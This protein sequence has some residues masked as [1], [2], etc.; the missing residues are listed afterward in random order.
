MKNKKLVTIVMA[1]LALT[2]LTIGTLA[3]FTDRFQSEVDVTAGTL[4]LTLSQNWESDNAA[5]AAKF[6]PGTGLVLN[7]TL[8]N[9]GNLAANV[10]EKIVIST[11]KDLT[12]AAP[13]FALYSASDVDVAADGDVT[14]HDGATPIA[15]VAGT[16]TEEGTGNTWHKLTY[17]F[18]PFVLNGNVEQPD[19]ASDTKGGAY[20]VVFSTKATNDFQAATLK[21]EYLA[22]GLQYG[23]TGADTWAD[24]KVI[25]AEITFGGEK[26]NVV[27]ELPAVTP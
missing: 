11:D 21:V 10:K 7:Y 27:P 22:Q 20:V 1:V 6:K 8:D 14:I 25:S 19:G 23:N 16:Y 24:A 18:G 4:D 15:S 9:G 2:A 26:V 12:D 17:E 3:L 5:V 13:E